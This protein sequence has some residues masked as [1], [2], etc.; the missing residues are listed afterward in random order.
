[1]SV[2]P[3]PC[4]PTGVPRLACLA[5]GAAALASMATVRADDDWALG[6]RTTEPVEASRQRASFRIP[7]GFEVQLVAHEPDIHKPM[8]LAF[9]AVGRLWVT[10][11]IEYPF[12]APTNRPARDRL[13][14]FEDFGAD[15]RARRIT[16]FAGGLNIPIGVH[17]WRSRN[18]DGRETWKALVWS[19]PHIWY[20]ED[21][22]GDGRADRREPW[23]GPFDHTRDTHGNQASFRRGFDGWLYATHGFNNDSRVTSRDGNAL[24]LNSGNTYRMRLDGT[25]LEH[26]TWGQVNPFGLTSRAP[27]IRAQQ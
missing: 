15:G 22:D 2:A 9:D 8:N 4:R 26:H 5:L 3:S 14:V 18:P 6:V 23:Y 11:S 27:A 21:T 13:M 7:E 20:L 12:A 16:E 25:R 17:P 1:M 10:T 24:H 19:I